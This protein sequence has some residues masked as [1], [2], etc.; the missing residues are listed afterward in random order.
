[1]SAAFGQDISSDTLSAEVRQRCLLCSCALGLCKAACG[2][3]EVDRRAASGQAAGRCASFLAIPS[4]GRPRKSSR[5]MSW[6]ITSHL[7]CHVELSGL[8]KDGMEG[9]MAPL[10][11]DWLPALRGC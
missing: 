7:P 1:M 11:S 8:Q 6:H 4:L 5:G 2:R 10:P 9:M 3:W